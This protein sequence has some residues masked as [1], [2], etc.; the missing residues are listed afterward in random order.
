MITLVSK[1][2]GKAIS[3]D[4][5]N[6]AGVFKDAVRMV[7]SVS[8]FK[9]TIPSDWEEYKRG[10]LEF[11]PPKKPDY[12]QS[13]KAFK[14]M[15]DEVDKDDPDVRSMHKNLMSFI[16]N[17]AFDIKRTKMKENKKQKIREGLADLAAKAEQ[18]HEIQMAR[19]EL[20]KLSKYSIKLHD[21]L[22][23]VSEAEGLQAWQQSYITKAAEYIDAV[24]HDL[25]YEK[26][27]DSEIS[28]DM[29]NAQSVEENK[30]V[31]DYT[32]TLSSKLA[33]TIKKRKK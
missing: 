21:L 27:M 33:E 7:S 11:N 8:S 24:Y 6:D 29:E 19:S 9:N 1:K 16:G 12:R 20:Y 26:S 4:D 28:V 31:K 5:P 22:K 23:T 17:T 32:R 30:A 14:N 18:D 2:A 25:S 10:S 13:T 3:F 15:T